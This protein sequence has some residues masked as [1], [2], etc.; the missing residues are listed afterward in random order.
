M[1][2]TGVELLFGPLLIGVILSTGVYG[3]MSVQMLQ[4]Y[5]A[6]KKDARWIRFFMLYLFFAE[7]ANLLFEIG[8]IYEPLIVRYG[9]QQALI[10]SPLLLPGDAISIVMVSTPVQLFTAWRISVITG[11]IVL[12][13]IISVLSIASFG[14]GLLVTVFV[15]I[16][17][18]FREFQSF[19]GAVIVWLIC[20]AVCDV[21]IAGVLTYSLTT[22][23]TGFTAVDGQ[24][25]RIIRLT[26]QTGSIT[27]VA[28]LADLILF[29]A[30]PTATLNFI[31]DFPLS[32]LYTISLLSTLNARARG[33]SDDAEQRLPNA[34][35]NESTTQKNTVL[36]MR[37][38]VLR[39]PSQYMNL[40]VQQQQNTYQSSNATLVAGGRSFVRDVQDAPPKEMHYPPEWR[41]ETT[42]TPS[43][44]KPPARF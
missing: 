36:T 5:Q 42:Y 14:G 2:G 26:V 32:K 38:S 18:E 1:A 22:R 44:R 34:L 4:Y 35:F 12:P 24:I 40:H 13:L 10:T 29:L 30:F 15:S 41:A 17:N 43:S 39:P 19:S 11:S 8:I 16:R 31:P 9:T 21:L 20:S 7:T 25:N 23:K 27:A 37:N 28:A 33:R 6:Y 3:V